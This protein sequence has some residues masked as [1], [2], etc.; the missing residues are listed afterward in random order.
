MGVTIRMQETI[1]NL[2]ILNAQEVIKNPT[3]E[4]FIQQVLNYLQPERKD[5]ER[6]NEDQ[7]MH[8]EFG[9]LHKYEHVIKY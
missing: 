2:K 3:I 5:F 8:V 4:S 1:R 6:E 7:I 9:K